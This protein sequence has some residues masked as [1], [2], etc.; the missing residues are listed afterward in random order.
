MENLPAKQKKYIHIRERISL[1]F[2]VDIKGF[3]KYSLRFALFYFYK[4][5]KHT[6]WHNKQSLLSLERAWGSVFGQCHVGL[7]HTEQMPL[8]LG[9]LLSLLIF[10]GLV[11]FGS[12]RFLYLTHRGEVGG[13]IIMIGV[14]AV[15]PLCGLGP[16]GPFQKHH[17]DDDTWTMMVSSLPSITND[18]TLMSSFWSQP[19][20]CQIWIVEKNDTHNI[21]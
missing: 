7:I 9:S 13:R 1:T 18:T 2:L 12:V 14:W 21:C 3:I 17:Y 16:S 15:W 10:F 20:A 8:W 4:K 11:W 5:T 6:Q 19:Y